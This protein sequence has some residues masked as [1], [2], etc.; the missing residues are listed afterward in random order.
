MRILAPLRRRS[1][2][3][4]WS[5]L[6]FSALGDQFNL[7]VLTWV[8]VDTLGPKAGYLSA[9]KAAIILVVA[10]VGG[11]VANRWDSRRTMVGADLCRCFI[12]LALVAAWLARGQPDPWLL[13]ATIV[14]LATA[15]AFFVPALQSTLPALVEHPQLLVA[16]NGL[17][18]ATDR[19]ARLLGPGLVAV[20]GALVAPVHFFTMDAVS[21][22]ISAVAVGALRL[23]H[24]RR[25][26]VTADRTSFRKNIVGG[27]HAVRREPFLG[28][29]L[30]V[31]GLINGAWYAVFLLALP[32]AISNYLASSGGIGLGTYGFIF[33]C[34]GAG[35]LA[36]NLTVG[37]RLLPKRPAG[38]I[39]LGT[40]LCGAGIILMALA[41]TLITTP[42]LRV[43][44]VTLS[45]A[46]SGFGA[47]LKDLPFATL[48]QLL[49]PSADIAP[50]MRAYLVVAYAGLLIGMLLA[51]LAS[52]AFGSI[53]VMLLAGA[54]YL[55]I[56]VVGWLRFSDHQI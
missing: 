1:V 42:Y 19:L 53:D 3:L 26:P 28:Y 6:A 20:V 50:A 30:S 11:T 48:R 31:T 39:F 22:L 33:S 4:V 17:F 2:A 25:A 7:V 51:P 37:S 41:C 14:V 10:L 40:C 9:A 36:A 45:A 27:F 38:L 16:T 34:Y 49:I 24:E 23:P 44:G 54:I 46:M 29:L 21:F 12:L 55:M 47:P 5:A 43:L 18:D 35:N 32:L 56:A 8:A 13:V 52:T 15:E